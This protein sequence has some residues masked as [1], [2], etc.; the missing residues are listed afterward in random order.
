LILIDGAHAK[1]YENLISTLG[2]SILIIT[3]I[4]IKREKFERYEKEDAFL[5]KNTYEK[6]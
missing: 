5:V 3:D 4:Y 6:L 2:I 1:V